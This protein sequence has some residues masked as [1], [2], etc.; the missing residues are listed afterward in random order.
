MIE[1]EFK[2]K[3]E[4]W[5]GDLLSGYQWLEFEYKG[6]RVLYVCGRFELSDDGSRLASS[7]TQVIGYADSGQPLDEEEQK[8]VRELLKSQQGIDNLSF[9]SQTKP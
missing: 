6:R 2:Q 8:G 5:Y 3:W 9:W 4:D 7:F 1:K